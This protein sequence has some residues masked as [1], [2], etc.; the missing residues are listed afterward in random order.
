M[1][2]LEIVD[3]SEDPQTGTVQAE[4]EHSLLYSFM[5]ELLFIFSTE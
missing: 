3:E 1:T 5:D 2:D 4:D